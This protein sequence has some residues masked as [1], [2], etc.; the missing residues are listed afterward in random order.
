MELSMIAK[1]V[2]DLLL[3]S[4]QNY[5]KEE[6][7]LRPDLLGM[8]MYDTEPLFCAASAADPLFEELKKPGVIG[9]EYPLPT[10]WL[11][12]AKS[13]ISFFLPFT[14]VVRVANRKAPRDVIADEWYHARVEGQIMMNEVGAFVCSLLEQEGH[15]AVYPAASED[16]RLIEPF[17]PNWSERHT[18]YV[19]GLGT[20]GLSKG[21]ITKRGMAG[22]YGSVITSAVITPTPR[23]YSDPFE[24]CIRCGACQ[25]LCPA[26]AID[27]QRGIAQ[28]KSNPMCAA[29]GKTKI[30]PPQRPGQR[31]HFGCGKCQVGVPCETRIP[32]RRKDSEL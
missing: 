30:T 18:A 19:C 6:E 13:V 28:A 20:F 32:P 10:D 23:E 31:K 26:D 24:Y 14:E 29:Y 7:S 11:P 8:Q 4:P 9:P 12:E 2:S 5:I 16:F 3:R 22:R 25:R 1:Q 27:A 21:L 17:F 15:K